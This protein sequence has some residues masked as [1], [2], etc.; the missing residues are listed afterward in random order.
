[1]TVGPI[2][3]SY[4][5]ESAFLFNAVSC[6]HLTHFTGRLIH[7]RTISDER[8]P[9]EHQRTPVNLI[10]EKRKEKKRKEKKTSLHPVTCHA[11]FLC[12]GPHLGL[13]SHGLCPVLGGAWTQCRYNCLS[14]CLLKGVQGREETQHVLCRHVLIYSRSGRRTRPGC[15]HQNATTVVISLRLFWRLIRCFA[16]SSNWLV[17][18][19]FAQRRDRGIDRIQAFLI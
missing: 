18:R 4:P 1:V 12:Y 7:V 15:R 16:L 11:I 6:E 3:T 14:V 9:L 5:A 10:T 8:R 2:H 13:I 17:C 19:Y